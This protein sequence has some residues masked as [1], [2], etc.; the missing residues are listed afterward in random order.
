MCGIAGAI[1]PAVP[2]H[3]TGD[4]LDAIAH[5]GPDGRGVQHGPH[6]AVGAVRLSIVGG[7]GGSQP[8]RS[9]GSAA[10]IV[11]NGEIY[12]YRRLRR[13][14]AAGGYEFSTQTDTEVIL[15][16]YRRDGP[17]CVR[18]LEGMYAVAIA[19]G[20]ALFLARDPVGMKPL[21]VYA[22]PGGQAL[23]FASEIKALLRVPG[24][25]PALDLSALADSA[26]VGHPCGSGTFVAGVRCLLPGETLTARYDGGRL[27][28]GGARPHHAVAIGPAGGRDLAGER[29]ARAALAG[30]VT[31]HLEADPG[32]AIAL[33]GGVDSALLAALAGRPLSSFTVCATG[34][35][36]DAAAARGV[37]RQLGL[38]HREVRVRPASYAGRIAAAVAVEEQPPALGA[39]PLSFLFGSVA[40]QAK[41]CVMG[42]GADEVFGGY[43]D[44]VRPAAGLHARLQARLAQLASAGLR[45]TPAALELAELRG[46]GPAS[47]LAA[48]LGSALVRQHLEL[49]DKYSMASGVEVR[50]PYLDAGVY[51]AGL[52]LTSGSRLGETGTVRK[53]LLREMLAERMPAGSAGLLAAPKRGFPASGAGLLRGFARYCAEHVPERYARRHELAGVYDRTYQ[54]VLFDLFRHIMLDGRGRVPDGFRLADFLAACR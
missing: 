26:L 46:G 23:Y 19:D 17:G 34:E 37:A 36:P 27:T 14:L 50:L 9:P 15:G 32:V 3:V 39:L 4:M 31:T 35:D 52:A 13:S 41:V 12:N 2:R 24:L 33:S 5:R 29:R 21:Y 22:E 10:G 18:D 8:V 28:V 42:E 11:F 54:L 51:E 38:R 40:R 49:V 7:A 6:V 43:Q 47:A 44:Y 45:P 48:N 30:A 20:D 53:R 25:R 16:L 1:G